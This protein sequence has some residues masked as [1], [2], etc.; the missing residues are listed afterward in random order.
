MRLL[1]D[2]QNWS[3]YQQ[4]EDHFRNLETEEPSTMLNKIMNYATEAHLDYRLSYEEEAWSSCTSFCEV[5][6]PISLP[7]SC[8]PFAEP[9][10][11]LLIKLINS[12]WAEIDDLRTTVT[13]FF[14]LY[15]L[16]A[17]VGIRDSRSVADETAVLVRAV[18]A[19]VTDSYQH[20]RTDIGVT[21]DALVV[22]FLAQSSDW[23][24]G[25]LTAHY[26]IGMMLGHCLL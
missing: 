12:D 22:A 21:D 10:F 18:V 5:Y 20:H 1:G 11:L 14:L 9:V 16:P 19:L 13:V 17:V 7:L 23:Y 24:A 26:Q 2:W 25:L 8:C 6:W 3:N 15:A 4:E